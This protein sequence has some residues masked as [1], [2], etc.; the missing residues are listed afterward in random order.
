MQRLES[1]K[2]F[3]SLCV[4]FSFFL[5]RRQAIM[6]YSFQ[7]QECSYLQLQDNTMPLGWCGGK[8]KERKGPFL[9]LAAE[10]FTLLLQ[11]GHKT[12]WHPSRFAEGSF[13]LYAWQAS[14]HTQTDRSHYPFYLPKTSPV[15]ACRALHPRPQPF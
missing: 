9:L 12:L 11:T 14:R 8:T 2:R 10:S 13:L 1:S 5:G 15:L 3:S 6:K 7:R 4:Y